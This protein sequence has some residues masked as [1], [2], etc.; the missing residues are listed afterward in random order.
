[1]WGTLV[2]GGGQAQMDDLQSILGAKRIGKKKFLDQ[3]EKSLLTHPWLLQDGVADLAQKLGLE[4]SQT[5]IQKGFKSWWGYI[6][7]ARSFKETQAVLTK[8]KKAKVRMVVISNTDL[9]AFEFKIKK[10]GWQKFFE[11]FFLSADFGVLKPHRK[12]FQAVEKYLQLPKEKILM[13]DDSLYHGVYP[14][15]E[16][17]WQALWVARGREGDDT[18]KIEDLRGILKRLDV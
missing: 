10:L 14:A 18:D 9:P 2:E 13:V 17:G 7:R 1:M 4:V 12:I 5:V 8:L 3:V 6:Q 16:F 11:K 15:R